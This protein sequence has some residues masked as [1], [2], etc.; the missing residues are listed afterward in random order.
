VTMRNVFDVGSYF[1]DRPPTWAEVLATLSGVVTVVAEQDG[2]MSLP[3]A[4]A[5]FLLCLVAL[6]P[7]AATAGGQWLGR[8]F[9]GLDGVDRGLALFVL[10][11]TVAVVSLVTRVP[12]SGLTDALTGTLL[13]VLLYLLVHVVRAG[14]VSGW[15]TDTAD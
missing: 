7:G 3:V 9:R 2:S 10:F 6:G 4:A 5:G 13:A 1:P 11:A 15:T 8:W 12:E 14:G